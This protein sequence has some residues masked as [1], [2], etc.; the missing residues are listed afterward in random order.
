MKPQPSK[1]LLDL[2]PEKI[3]DEL[4]EEMHKN[5]QELSQKRKT[6][7]ES[8]DSNEFDHDRDLKHAADQLRQTTKDI[9]AVDQKIKGAIDPPGH[10]K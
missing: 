8:M 4:L 3:P 5:N 1:E 10:G 7:E 6:L 9:D 2:T